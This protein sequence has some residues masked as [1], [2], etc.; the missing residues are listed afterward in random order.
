M[1][2]PEQIGAL[3]DTLKKDNFSPGLIIVDTLSRVAVG[4]DENSAKDMGQVVA[5]FDDLKRRLDAT[6]LV[7]HHTRKD[8]GSERGSSALRGAADVMIACE[9]RESI[10]SQQGVGLT[11]AKMRDGEPFKTISVSLEKVDLPNGKSSLVLGSVFD[12]QAARSAHED[13]IV[14]ILETRFA[15]KGATHGELKKAFVDSGAGKDFTFRPCLEN[16]KDTSRIRIVECGEKMLLYPAE[17]SSKSP[18]S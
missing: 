11:C 2:D 8:G 15:D 17:V 16:L 10:T 5:G 1:R 9:K 4:A 18:A 6:V 12:I 13:K 7:I 14:E 3:H